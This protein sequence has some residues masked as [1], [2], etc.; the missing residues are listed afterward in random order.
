MVPK[1]LDADDVQVF[2]DGFGWLHA[3][4]IERLRPRRHVDDVAGGAFGGDVAES[5]VLVMLGGVGA[6]LEGCDADADVLDGWACP[7][8]RWRAAPW[9]LCRQCSRR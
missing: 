6:R 9:N 2:D 5:Y 7:C 8:P 4:E 1:A 3:L